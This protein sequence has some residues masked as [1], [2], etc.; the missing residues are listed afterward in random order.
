MN[1]IIITKLLEGELLE[2]KLLETKLCISY[3]RHEEVYESLPP[4]V[5]LFVLSTTLGFSAFLFVSYSLPC[6]LV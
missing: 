1:N 5:L 2:A 3:F 6:S 4:P